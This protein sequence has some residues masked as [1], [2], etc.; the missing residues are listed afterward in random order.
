MGL[1]NAVKKALQ[2]YKNPDTSTPQQYQS[3]QVSKTTPSP[4]ISGASRIPGTAPVSNVSAEQAN[5]TPSKTT[6]SGGGGSSNKP[7]TSS[8]PNTNVSQNTTQEITRNNI[9]SIQNSR[10]QN[11][12]EL[13]QRQQ[14]IQNLARQNNQG[15]TQ[16]T[17][18]RI[19]GTTLGE[20]ER[21][22]RTSEYKE[23]KAQIAKEQQ[24]VQ[25]ANTQSNQGY[26][27]ATRDI[28][29]TVSAYYEPTDS[30][31]R[32]I[33]RQNR[34]S[35]SLENKR[36]RGESIKPLDYVQIAGNTL[37]SIPL[38]FIKSMRDGSQLFFNLGANAGQQIEDVVP[39]E[40][41]GKAILKYGNPGGLLFNT[42]YDFGEYAGR[43]NLP[44]RAIEAVG[45]TEKKVIEGAA[46]IGVQAGS[47]LYNAVDTTGKTLLIAGSQFGPYALNQVKAAPNTISNTLINANAA[48][49]AEG[50]QRLS[51]VRTEA[52]QVART[53]PTQAK[54]RLDNVAMS[55]VRG[56]L[57]V[58]EGVRN[59]PTLPLQAAAN[60]GMGFI[61]NVAEGSIIT[62]KGILGFVGAS[63][64]TGERLY[65]VVDKVGRTTLQAGLIFGTQYKDS[66]RVVS[67]AADE[68]VTAL[69]G[70]IPEFSTPQLPFFVRQAGEDVGQTLTENPI[71]ASIQYG[72]NILLSALPTDE[73]QISSN[74]LK[75]TERVIEPTLYSRNVGNF[76][77]TS[78]TGNRAVSDVLPVIDAA[79]GKMIYVSRSAAARVNPS[80]ILERSPPKVVSLF[81]R[82]QQI[83]LLPQSIDVAV[84]TEPS[85][86]NT[87]GFLLNRPRFISGEPNSGIF[88]VSRLE[89]GSSTSVSLN[90]FRNLP[91][92]QQQ[93]F[94]QAYEQ[95]FGRP[96]SPQLIEQIFKNRKADTGYVEARKLYNVAKSKEA[97]SLTRPQI[98]K[99]ITRSSSLATSDLL[100]AN[101]EYSIFKVNVASG[102]VSLPEVEGAATNIKGLVKLR[103]QVTMGEPDIIGFQ[104]GQRLDKAASPKP[105]LENVA[106]QQEVLA[107]SLPTKTS[108]L[109]VILGNIEKDTTEVLSSKPTT[110]LFYGKGQY[111]KTTEEAVVTPLQGKTSQSIQ[112]EQSRIDNVQLLDFK[113]LTKL[114]PKQN[115]LLKQLSN[116][117]NSQRGKETQVTVQQTVQQTKQ[118]QIQS[119]LQRLGLKSKISQIKFLKL[120]AL[121]LPFPRNSSV[122]SETR[123]TK[124]SKELFKIFTKRFGK[125]K[126]IGFANTK[127]GAGTVLKKELLGTLGASGF[128]ED[129]FGRKVSLSEL[130]LGPSFRPAKYES[131]RAVQKTRGPS[132]RLGSFSERKEIQY[133]KKKKSKKLNL[134]G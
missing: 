15:L 6:I 39:K 86:I 65:Q 55:L 10:P 13:I 103:K 32:A 73:V 63:E 109:P 67:K 35:S 124:D 62:G 44:K 34:I 58:N 110:S 79:T 1:I 80:L 61:G 85:I 17:S 12:Q 3:G 46:K 19:L 16:S 87:E 74:L 31:D 129:S 91:E 81:F 115:N 22:K 69:T 134:L 21:I 130:N 77:V 37:G 122:E 40:K 38:V 101:P 36:F 53:V 5:T 92:E 28:I 54:Q 47:N 2:P 11:I 27:P 131:S 52:A 126:A 50:L 88:G 26:N 105:V 118:E 64:K 98:G 41:V 116:T 42:A 113:P 75:S 29:P 96:A 43:T 100:L 30:L 97:I 83:E 128:V 59:N 114:S 7:S 66:P 18:R 82:P 125:D 51:S 93:I 78:Q 4:N 127:S 108:N 60:A 104:G 57:V 68:Q 89:S 123:S 71:R 25:T 102:D 48:V 56:G 20:N 84:Q 120:L 8:L 111:E 99:S 76:L 70:R 24:E 95:R 23:A 94:L 132:N 106:K 49:G 117:I 9:P 33:A 112:I 72:S 119:Q 90:N 45:N 133:F 14:L 107:K 121:P